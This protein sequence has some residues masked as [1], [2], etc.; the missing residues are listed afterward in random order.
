MDIRIIT[1]KIFALSDEELIKFIAFFE[2]ETG[3]VK[4]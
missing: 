1:K 3:Q 2:Q 4:S